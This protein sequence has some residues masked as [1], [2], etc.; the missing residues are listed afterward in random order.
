MRRPLASIVIVPLLLFGVAPSPSLAAEWTDT[1]EPTARTEEERAFVLGQMRLFLTAVT[2]IED[3]LGA[4]D[5]DHVAREA[6]ARGRKATTTLVRPP[7]IAAK[8]SDSWKALIVTM[9]SGF[10]QI[11]D[12]ATAHAPVQQINKTLADTMH[13]C[14]AC[15][16]TYRITVDGR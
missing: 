2:E 8:E 14:I 4:G 12:Q 9:R 5:M 6:T 15:H 13:T 1:R 16:Q 11:A 7:T 10:D 3:G